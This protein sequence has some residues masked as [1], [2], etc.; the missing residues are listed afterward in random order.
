MVVN[1]LMVIL[2]ATPGGESDAVLADT[3]N[4]VEFVFENK[5]YGAKSASGPFE[6]QFEF[7]GR[8]VYSRSGC[9]LYEKRAIQGRSYE[10]GGPVVQR[11]M[12]V[13]GDIRTHTLGADG[14][15]KAQS[16]DRFSVHKL[17]DLNDS[18]LT[19]FFT[20]YFHFAEHDEKARWSIKSSPDGMLEVRG[21]WARD[22]VFT[23]DPSRGCVP[24]SFE[25]PDPSFHEQMDV[26]AAKR[27]RGV[28]GKEHWFPIKGVS[29][30]KASETVKRT[31]AYLTSTGLSS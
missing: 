18:P 17:R 26:K 3:I 1:N 16:L 15:V 4:D 7:G 24:V 21:K 8:V 28:D 6:I 27:I 22:G 25:G 10:M 23:L 29:T 30:I 12:R 31:A 5:Q 13:G 2:L 20:P 11:S 19:L 9:L 14:K